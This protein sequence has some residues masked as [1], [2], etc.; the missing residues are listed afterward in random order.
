MK[1]SAHMRRALD[2]RAPC[3]LVE[4]AETLGSTPRE[5]GA[6]MLVTEVTSFD[7]IGGGQLEFHVIDVARE[8]LAGGGA[9]RS[10]NLALGPHMGQCCGGRVVVLLK[11]LTQALALEQEALESAE[12]RPEVLIFGAGH[13]GL[14]LSRA[15]SLL[16]LDVS[17]IDDR[18]G[19]NPTL[20]DQI[21][22]RRV[23][24]PETAITE[25]MAGAAVVIL[26]HSHALDYA[27]A[28]AALRRSDLAYVGMIG[29]ATKRARF[30]QWFRARGGSEEALARLVCPIGGKAIRDKRPEVIAALTSAE[31]VHRILAE[32]SATSDAGGATE[33]P[34]SLKKKDI[35]A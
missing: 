33:S 8:M 26:T 16:P 34:N 31:I 7:T 12:K 27:L 29:S 23:D 10:L 11:K 25:A 30:R 20:P 17:L 22:F 21:A 6:R 24:N 5:A 32:S 18:E 13:T 35:A 28:D 2:V 9:A 14:A 19:L 4:I 1:L 3:I 15:L